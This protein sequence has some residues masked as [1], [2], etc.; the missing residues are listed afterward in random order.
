MLFGASS[1]LQS[2]IGR[3]SSCIE[4]IDDL[5]AVYPGFVC[6]MPTNSQNQG[7]VE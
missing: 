2:G 4:I 7:S 3:E 1:V 6:D 5:K